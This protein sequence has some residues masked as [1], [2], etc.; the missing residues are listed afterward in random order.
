MNSRQVDEADVQAPTDTQTDRH[1][2]IHHDTLRI[3]RT[4]LE[5]AAAVNSAAGEYNAAQRKSNL[6]NKKF[7]VSQHQRK[8][9]QSNA[10]INVNEQLSTFRTC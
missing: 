6:R 3:H 2:D 7:I 4:G 10:C 5:A 9:N 1:A 8:H